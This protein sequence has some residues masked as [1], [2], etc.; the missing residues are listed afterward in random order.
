MKYKPYE[1]RTPDGQ[2]KAILQRIL[3]E[4]EFSTTRQGPRAK[5]VIGV[6][7]HFR[8]DNGFPLITDRSIKTFWQK[9]IGELCAFIN[10]A[11]T[12]DEL[13]AFGCTWWDA[14]TSEEKTSKRGL[15]FGDIGPGSYGAA[16]H[17]FPTADG[18]SFDQFK[19]L[20]EQIKELPELRTHFVTPWIPQ[21]IVRGKGKQQKVTIAPCHG[22]V[23][24]RIINDKLHLHMFQRSGDFPIGVPSNMVQYAALALML[25]S[26][27][28]YEAVEYVH[29]ISDAHIYEDQIEYLTP[30]L[31]RESL[32]L[33]TVRLTEEG[34]KITD[35]HDFRMEHFELED[36]FPH[37]SIPKI[38]VAT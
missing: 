8:L 24:V 1:E 6:Q 23:H 35:I 15:A 5:T 14:W 17:D 33:P 19:H 21:Y 28:G 18:G 27:T 26:L 9:P 16:F 34:K 36:Y 4:G 29:T 12:R 30:M 11:R 2:Y 22:W 37:P 10:G 7:M 31:D 38:P 13:A 3:A 32:R 25:E 20:V